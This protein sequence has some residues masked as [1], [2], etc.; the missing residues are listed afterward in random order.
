MPLS[1]SHDLPKLRFSMETPF[2]SVVNRILCGNSRP[3]S[4]VT[5]TAQIQ[6]LQSRSVFSLPLETSDRQAHNGSFVDGQPEQLWGHSDDMFHPVS[7]GGRGVVLPA[8]AGT[9]CQDVPRSS[10]S[11]APWLCVSGPALCLSA[12]CVCFGLGW[13]AGGG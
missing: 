13:M 3:S 12:L 11:V 8:P 5:F 2:V 1:G 9:F 10:R 6:R 4:P 7:W